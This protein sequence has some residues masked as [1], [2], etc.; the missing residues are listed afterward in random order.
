[1]SQTRLSTALDQ[2]LLQLPD[3][4]LSVLRPPAGYDLSAVGP[5]RLRISH[6]FRPDFEFWQATGVPVTVAPVTAPATLVVLPRAKA[7]ARGMIAQ[8]CALSGLII[9]DGQRTDG[10]DS[11]WREL[12]DRLGEMPTVTKAH[13]R[14]FWFPV[15]DKMV[16][17]AIA[18]PEPDEAGFYR[19]PGVFSESGIDRGSQVLAAALPAKLPAR[20][21][22]LGAGW[23]YLSAAAL[24][25]TGLQQIDLIEAE[26]LSLDCARLNVTDPRA[27][28]VW[29][30]VTSHTP[31]RAYDAVI[32]N[33]PFHAG[34]A[35]EPALGQAFIAAAARLLAPHGQLWMVSNR[36]LP[37]ETAL[38]GKFR[39]LAEVGQDGAFKVFH[40]TR[41]LR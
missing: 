8:A 40:A 18:A 4:P 19:Q 13:G 34:R 24:T 36:H 39:N 27:R 6:G 17:W 41:P 15:T 26:S 7:L 23:G 2:G 29:A 30:D 25:R 12:R 32:M 37:Y 35:A 10:V 11:L 1:M 5:E 22:D 33:P 16:D 20:I 21:A 9:V 14:M 31:D 28:F 3:G 38:R